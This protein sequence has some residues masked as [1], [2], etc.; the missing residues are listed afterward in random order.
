MNTPEPVV[1]GRGRYRLHLVR[2]GIHCCYQV[3]WQREYRS[4]T[5]GS[6][7]CRDGTVLSFLSSPPWE[8]T[9]HLFATESEAAAF[10]VGMLE[11]EPFSM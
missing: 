7:R 6:V 1:V 9:V 5:R 3:E 8:S 10:A 11:A 4:L 2:S